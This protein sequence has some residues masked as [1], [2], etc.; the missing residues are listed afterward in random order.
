MLINLRVIGKAIFCML[1]ILFT[2]G[3]A[4][5]QTIQ[6]QD[7]SVAFSAFKK[8]RALAK[9][10][11]RDSALVSYQ[12][13]V[14][15]Y[16]EAEA[17]ASAI[18]T[19][20][21][22]AIVLRQ[23]EELEKADSLLSE[24][25]HLA[26]QKLEADHIEKAFLLEQ[27]GT[28]KKKQKDFDLSFKAYTESLEMRKRLFGET[29]PKVA[30]NFNS[31]GILFYEWSDYEESLAYLEKSLQIRRAHFGEEHYTTARMYNNIG[32]VLT[33]I[34][35]YNKSIK[36]LKKAVEIRSKLDGPEH[37][38]VA[39]GYLGLA[40]VYTF[41]QDLEEAIALCE[42]AI[43]IF[44]NVYGENHNEVLYA[45]N[46]VATAHQLAGNF[47]KAEEYIHHS[48]RLR[49]ERE[50]KD[51]EEIAHLNYVLGK[52]AS[53]KNEYDEASQRFQV[54]LKQISN[55][56]LRRKSI[57][58]NLLIE[59]A[60]VKLKKGD[61]SGTEKQLELALTKA[62][63]LY[64]EKNYDL[65][66]I[67][68]AYA[69]LRIEKNRYTSASENLNEAALALLPGKSSLPDNGLPLQLEITH[70]GLMA[71]ILGEHGK[72]YLRLADRNKQHNDLRLKQYN[73]ALS[74]FTHGCDLIEKMR[75]ERK[76]EFSKLTIGKKRFDLYSNAVTTSMMLY[77]NTNE[78]SYLENA[79]LLTERSKAFVLNE[80][81]TEA[82]AKSIAGIPAETLSEE[83]R[84]RGAY[85]QYE[86]KYLTEL[87]KGEKSD[88][89][90]VER[91]QSKYFD[92]RRTY[93]AHIS[94]MEAQ[95]PEYYRLKHAGRSLDIPSLQKSLPENGAILS[96][97][98]A[99]QKLYSFILT[100]SDLSVVEQNLTGTL[101]KDVK[102]FLGSIT[103]LSDHSAFVHRSLNLFEKIWKP[104]ESHLTGIE[105]I[106]IIPDGILAYMPFEA[107]LQSEPEQGVNPPSANHYVLSK[108]QIS[109]HYS[110]TLFA[111]SRNKNRGE[112]AKY[113]FGGYA[114][115]F[116]N[117]GGDYVTGGTS[118]LDD[119]GI[120][121]T[122]ATRSGGRM[123]PLVH[124]E[125]EVREIVST[126]N[127]NDR[128]S[129][130]LLHNKATEEHFK[131]TASQYGIIHLATHSF[132][133]E[134]QPRLSGIA[135]ADI[136]KNGA[137]EDG[138]LFA[139]EIYNLNLNADL[140]VMS[141]CESGIGQ[142]VR[143]EGLMAMTR[144]FI[145]AGVPNIAVSLWKVL[146]RHTSLLMVDFYKNVLH[147][148]SYAA[149]MRE[150]KLK[151]LDNPETAY[152]VSWSSFILVGE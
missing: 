49:A 123:V 136:D 65:A 116:Q 103:K 19:N 52:I 35:D 91:L 107:L 146:D 133:N 126:F 70:E 21:Y 23:K 74:Y 64:S 24:T 26:D 28:I 53:E 80:A 13:A 95:Y 122:E 5:F 119:I 81:F 77:H 97:F 102:D 135:F 86:S 94:K 117:K 1:P 9:A 54:G 145:Y 138:I 110:A 125:K 150:A 73:K 93:D 144:G 56:E 112:A 142:L 69:K 7:T 109:Y 17:F 76:G 151:M 104:L 92:A 15:Q 12:I 42:K 105:K 100:H 57:E 98:R 88:K 67:Y 108:Y 111:E 71:E 147:G 143:G 106:H 14:N 90:K 141:S 6:T 60:L 38:N 152:P 8:G 20:V 30:K 83:T 18:R 58:I 129:I 96:Y 45:Y 132:V 44:I 16:L 131:E 39:K 51:Y 148:K 40:R 50:D 31:L 34:G 139:N 36:Y 120:F 47:D 128:A 4:Q 46:Y 61:V 101:E 68:L 113:M 11:K 137:V 130:G 118:L 78:S 140:V 55:L 27:L 89:N 33:D 62:K 22:A 72:L 43:P 29:H 124:S 82:N 115:V 32:L 87:A 25:M 79:F 59:S 66:R 3:N 84:L 41:K 85:T 127:S 149:A 10:A 48:L 121:L 114:P 2:L 134:S 63:A 75:R 99:D 37:R